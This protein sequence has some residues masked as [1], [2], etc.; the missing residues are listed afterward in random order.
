MDNTIT[1]RGKVILSLILFITLCVIGYC[2]YLH[3]HTKPVTPESQRQA[4]TPAG[5]SLAAHNAKVRMMQDQLDDAAQQIA[6]LKNKQPDTIIKT[7]PYEV[8]KVVVKEVEKRGADFAIV[9]D[10][11]H[12]DKKVDLKEVEKLPATTPVTLNQYNVFAY[13]K[14]IRGVNVYPK[15]KGVTPTGISELTYDVSRKISKDGK[16]I[17]FVGGYDFEDRKAKVGLRVT[18]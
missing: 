16:Y 4:E 17:G 11:Q 7:V 10:P 9:T 18:F 13:K 5:V 1:A 12:P 2:G 15:F 6:I 8:E 3:L 14:I